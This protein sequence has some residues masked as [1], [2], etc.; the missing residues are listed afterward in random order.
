MTSYRSLLFL[1]LITAGIASAAAVAAP[2][3]TTYSWVATS[4]STPDQ[5]DARMGLTDTATP[6]NPVLGPTALTLSTS[7]NAENMFYRQFGADLT[8]PAQLVIEAGLRMGAGQST[9]PGPVA[10]RAHGAIVFSTG[11]NVGN[12]LFIGNDRVFLLVGN[13]NL[14]PAALVDTDDALHDY[15]I[16]VDGVANGADIRVFQDGNLI[17]SGDI[18][19]GGIFTG[20]VP[21]IVFGEQTLAAFGESQWTYFRHNA[22]T[23]T[24]DAPGSLALLFAGLIGCA[25]ARRRAGGSRLA[26][27][28]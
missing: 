27:A 10:P 26:A 18:F 2:I 25:A 16:E 19:S 3:A 1:S 14:G 23:G 20:A 24:V 4:G 22:S 6:E 12:A 13:D 28:Q 11:P 9:Q 8:M 17:L 7:A 15:R 21:S 5:V